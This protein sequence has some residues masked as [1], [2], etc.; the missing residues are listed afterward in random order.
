MRSRY[1]IGELGTKAE[2]RQHLLK[3]AKQYHCFAVA[4]VLNLPPELCHERNQHRPDRQ[5][6]EHIVRRHSDNIRR[7]LKSLDREGFRFIY[8]L[9]SVAQINNVTIDR[10]PLWS[11][12]NHERGPFD[13]LGDIHGC[14]DELEMLL[15]KLGYR[16]QPTANLA[17]DSFW[18]FPTYTHPEG[19]KAIFVGDLVDRG[20]RILDT[21]KLVHNMMVAGSAFCV[22]GNHEFKLLKYLRG[23]KVKINYGLDKSIAE[24]EAITA[25]YRTAHRQELEKFLDSL[26]AHYTIDDGKL[27]VAHAGLKE[28]L[29]GRTSGAVRSFA[30]YGVRVSLSPVDV[31]MVLNW[32]I[33]AAN[34]W[35]C[36]LNRFKSLKINLTN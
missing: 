28:E 11:N 13:I 24:I 22:C 4:I 10:V 33:G 20:D 26:I 34:G 35:R 30:M 17:T 32:F 5:F 7:S 19:R 12:L 6:G 3:L 8:Q 1:S 31:I 15:T 9:N 2:D 16:S 14:A 36:S 27:V 25:E 23:K 21:V 18:Q 29:Q